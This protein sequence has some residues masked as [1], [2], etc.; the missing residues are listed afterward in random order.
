MSYK[1][2]RPGRDEL[3]AGELIEQ[4]ALRV[5]PYYEAHNQCITKF[6]SSNYECKR[7]L[8]DAA[9]A[10]FIIQLQMNNHCSA[11]YKH[12]LN[13]AKQSPVQPSA[14]KQSNH[15]LWQC[16]DSRINRHTQPMNLQ[17]IELQEQQINAARHGM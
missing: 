1:P 8:N 5:R 10:I 13:V 7:A 2:P 11:Q 12:Y 17:Q 4:I 9:S 15:S 6:H 16:V 3:I 14:L